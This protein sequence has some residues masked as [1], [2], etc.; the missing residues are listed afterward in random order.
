MY[1][2]TIVELATNDNTAVIDKNRYLNPN[3]QRTRTPQ[4]SLGVG[5]HRNWLRPTIAQNCQRRIHRLSKCRL[6]LLEINY[7]R[8]G[9][10]L[11]PHLIRAYVHLETYL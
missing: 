1:P 11:L 7:Q 2:Y 4:R 8:G 10:T 3:S 9:E 5:M 6:K